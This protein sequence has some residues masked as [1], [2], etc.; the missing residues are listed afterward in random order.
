MKACS[1]CSTLNHPKAFRCK[2]CEVKFPMTIQ[3]KE[4]VIANIKKKNSTTKVWDAAVMLFVVGGLIGIV[5][6]WKVLKGFDYNYFSYETFIPLVLGLWFIFLGI[7]S[8]RKPF[9]ALLLGT[10]SY[11]LCVLY[12]SLSVWQGSIAG[13]LI[14]IGIGV[15]MYIG[16]FNA[17][18]TNAKPKTTDIL[19]A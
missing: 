6:I 19:D 11:T 8:D 4:K 18:R 10:I 14:M 13:L 2:Y 9:W 16:L 15:Y 17:K 12:F 1:N 7:W 5:G 3:Q